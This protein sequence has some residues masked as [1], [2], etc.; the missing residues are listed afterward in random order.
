MRNFLADFWMRL[1][2]ALAAVWMRLHAG[3]A[4]IWIFAPIA[5]I[6]F[7]LAGYTWWWQKVAD[8]VRASADQFQIDQHAQGRE[9]QWDALDLSGFPY[10]VEALIS[11]PRV[12]A[13]DRGFA[14]DGKSVVLDVEPLKPGHIALSF[15]GH[16]HLL[17]AKDGRL[18]EGGADATKALVTI[19]AGL[20]GADELGLEI[21]GLSGQGDWNAKH[22]ELVVQNAT[23]SARVSD[24]GD[25]DTTTPPIAFAAT[26]N[27]IAL[28]GDLVLPLG[29]TIT[30]VDVQARFKFP[31]APPDDANMN[32]L[33]AWR[34]TQ[35]PIEIQNF[36]LD[37]GGVT[38]TA[39]G[40]LKLDAQTR[41]EGW[42]RLKVGNHRR[43]LEVLTAEGWISPDAQPSIAA[44]LNTLAFM[45]GDPERR[46]DVTVRFANGNAFLEL[47][48]L[49]P[50]RMG[51]VAP[52]FST[53][54]LPGSP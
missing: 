9:A 51:P 22:V 52:L 34:A 31:T 8:G 41:A 19:V 7:V 43:L 28:R 23:A 33:A 1:R 40:E 35:T 16:Q 48:G 14:W 21:E 11:G 30:L 53:P 42:L 47:F 15:Q 12:T 24:D 20:T 5:F 2:L 3:I 4:G 46:V 44:A 38:V 50:I 10:R 18:V 29:P 39:S 36:A 37:W 32:F 27:N 45:S 26:L 25:I 6:A 17:Y 13:P 54:P 49:V